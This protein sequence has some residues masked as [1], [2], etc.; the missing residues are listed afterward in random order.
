VARC[1]RFAGNFISAIGADTNN[2]YIKFGFDEDIKQSFQIGSDAPNLLVL[3]RT[4]HQEVATSRTEL[5]I[6]RLDASG[7]DLIGCNC[8]GT[9]WLFPAH[10]CAIAK[11]HPTDILFSESDMP[12]G[13]AC[14]GG[15]TA[16]AAARIFN[17]GN[18]RWTDR[19][20]DAINEKYLVGSFE[21]VPT[22]IYTVTSPTRKLNTPRDFNYFHRKWTNSWQHPRD[23]LA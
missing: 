16:V 23:H 11:K 6:D 14:L 2:I 21:K 17:A 20:G 8:I 13:V 4:S 10:T 7:L 22:E 19:A 1:A 18:N 12:A 3:D 9:F 15:T 5:W